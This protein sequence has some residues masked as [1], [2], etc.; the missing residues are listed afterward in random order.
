[1]TELKTESQSTRIVKTQPTANRRSKKTT[2]VTSATSSDIVASSDI[3]ASSGR[4]STSDAIAKSPSEPT[5]TPRTP[6]T[7]KTTQTR[8]AASKSSNQSASTQVRLTWEP[9][10][11][12]ESDLNQVNERLNETLVA[13]D[14]LKAIVEQLQAKDQQ[15]AA[16]PSSELPK[17]QISDR[18]QSQPSSQAPIRSTTRSPQPHAIPPYSP[19]AQTQS[20]KRLRRNKPL[21]LLMQNILQMPTKENEIAMDAALW[22]MAAAGLRVGLKYLVIAFPILEIPVMVL[23]FVPGLL[24]AYA[25][26]FIPKADRIGIYRLL[27]LALGLF[28]GG[29]L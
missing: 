9:P 29:R 5:Q 6:K 14:Q 24:A 25:A 12:I 13:F 17:V 11:T 16:R 4:E 21:Q 20:K 7:K 23:V 28:V 3:A 26:L 10:V 18:L 22:V 1:M 2:A 27:L 19:P 8:R 15:S